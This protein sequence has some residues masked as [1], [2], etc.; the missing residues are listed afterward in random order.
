MRYRNMR[1]LAL[2]FEACGRDEVVQNCRTVISDTVAI[3]KRLSFLLLLGAAP[4]T[5][6]A[7]VTQSATF[8]TGGAVRPSYRHCLDGTGGV[9]SDMKACMTTEFDFQDERLNLLYKRLMATLDGDGKESLRAEEREWI[10]RKQSKC[11]EGTEPGQADE[12]VA[13][14]CLVVETAKRAGELEARLRK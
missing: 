6:A 12:L 8:V 7:G 2:V 14:D 1:R 10:R 11:D 4:V 5:I 3:G 13:Y 9:T